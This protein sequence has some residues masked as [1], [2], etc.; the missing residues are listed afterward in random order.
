MKHILLLITFFSFFFIACQKEETTIGATI[1]DSLWLEH[2]GAQMPILVEGNTASKTF[3]LMLHGGPGGSSKIYNEVLQKMSRPLEEKY[4]VAY[5]D[6][7]LAGN[8]RGHYSDVDFNVA[9]LLEDTDLV[10]ELLK[11]RYGNDIDIFLLGHSWGGYLGNAY[12]A[13]GEPFQSKIKGWIDVAGAH[14]IEKII[15]DGLSLM[16]TISRQRIN[17]NSSIRSK[18]ESVLDFTKDYDSSTVIDKN[19]TIKVNQKANSAERMLLEDKLVNEYIFSKSESQSLLYKDHSVLSSFANLVQSFNS[20]IWQEILS[21]PL[22][23]QLHTIT[24]PSLL[25]WGKYDFVV[26]PSLGEEMLANLGTLEA[27]K[28]LHV[29]EKSGHSPMVSETD[30]FLNLVED[31]IDTYK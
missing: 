22:T 27:D 13:Q 21:K 6:Q 14:N 5:W 4:A 1:S 15:R 3:I 20:N 26:P 7:R 8:T 2:K 24:T 18:W 11:H 10:I 31:F 29:F 19:T 28:T 23:D 12:L 16:A 25:L 30:K 17:G 9:L